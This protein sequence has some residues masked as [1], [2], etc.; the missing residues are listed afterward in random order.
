MTP[1]RL[2]EVDPAHA[3]IRHVRDAEVASLV[4]WPDAIEA[5]KAA[6]AAA[7]PR[8]VPGRTT[9]RG[10]GCW[11]RALPA[12]SPDGAYVGAKM[13]SAS[14]RAGRASYLLALFDAT[15]MEL[16][17]LMDA[18]SITGMRTAATSAI[19]VDAITPQ[20]PLDV[21]I[22]G[23]GFE[24]FKHLSAVSAVRPL[25][26]IRVF[27]PR[28]TSRR[29][30]AADAHRELA[31]E[32]SPART[33]EEAVRGADLVIC[34]AR[35]SDETPILHG[36]W[37]APG[38]TVV[39]IG[40]TIPE[41][42]EADWVTFER[43]HAVIADVVDEVLHDTGDGIDAQKNGVDVEA[44]CRSLTEVIGGAVQVRESDDDIVLYKSVGSALQDITLGALILRRADQT[45]AGYE[46]PPFV[47]PV[48]K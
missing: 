9:A 8:A 20:G 44:K 27:S 13:I 10:D 34:A 43:A 42:R 26:T 48:S 39:S 24:A 6:Y 33:A 45:G 35:S 28:A 15:T 11:L 41:Q 18:N 32:V 19:A 47:I 16:R 21:A 23:S 14:P 12:V 25:G 7:D 3:P 46:T 29:R 1:L 38:A 37:L 2:A 5:L 40:S 36:D 17:A 31:L 30:F 22:L 4:T